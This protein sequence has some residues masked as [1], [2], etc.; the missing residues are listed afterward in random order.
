MCL[1]LHLARAR[2]KRKY[3]VGAGQHQEFPIPVA[4]WKK[5]W[6]AKQ[7]YFLL[8]DYTTQLDLMATKLVKLGGTKFTDP[9][10]LVV[11]LSTG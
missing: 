5:I 11:L 4:P 7:S 1:Y 9:W 10:Q 6:A 3:D 2:A 8:D